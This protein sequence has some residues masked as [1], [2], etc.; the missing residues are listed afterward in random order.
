M[1][2]WTRVQRGQ[3]TTADDERPKTESR[4]RRPPRSGWTVPAPCLRALVPVVR[5]GSL[6]LYGKERVLELACEGP[7]VGAA[8]LESMS[9]ENCCERVRAGRSNRHLC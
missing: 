8:V 5:E 3:G 4:E 1:T 6:K 2:E 7:G 9:Q